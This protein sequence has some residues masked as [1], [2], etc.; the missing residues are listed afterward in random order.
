M[1][2]A[3]AMLTG[4]G[5]GSNTATVGAALWQTTVRRNIG[6]VARIFFVTFKGTDLDEN[7]KSW[8]VVAGTYVL[9]LLYMC[10][11]TTIYVST[12][13]DENAQSWRIVAVCSHVLWE[14]L[15]TKP[16][17]WN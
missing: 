1:L 10:P 16:S 4:I 12:D 5:V 2:A 9:I 7:A 17:L 8:R 13:L 15:I 14:V 3:K 6:K 11:H